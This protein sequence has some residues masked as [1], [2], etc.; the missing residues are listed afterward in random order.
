MA[1]R[2]PVRLAAAYWRLTRGATLG[3]Q[4]I[5]FDAEGRVLLVRHGYRPGWH[6][7]GG[8]IEWGETAE[9]AV[10]R[11]LFEEAGIV[12]QGRPQFYGLFAAHQI[13]PND[14]IAV[15]IVREWERPVI[16][17]PNREILESRFFHPDEV[18]DNMAQG[19]ARRLREILSGAPPDP[20]W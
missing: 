2:I 12:I 6:F 13:V 9:D 1:H 3:A 10:V 20:R 11:E 16:P 7:P 19:A 15:F 8:G 18:P 14:H 4:G 5:V 17:R